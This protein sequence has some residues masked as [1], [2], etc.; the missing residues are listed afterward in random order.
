MRIKS[1]YVAALSTE[2]PTICYNYSL[3]L[4]SSKGA[5]T[6]A[7]QQK[8]RAELAALT[9]ATPNPTAESSA[10]ASASAKIPGKRVHV[11]WRPLIDVVHVEPICV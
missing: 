4:L 3:P 5:S 1:R 6:H 11:L 8:A 10:S 2:A 7:K 9:N